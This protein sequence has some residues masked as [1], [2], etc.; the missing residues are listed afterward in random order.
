MSCSDKLAPRSSTCLAMSLAVA[1]ERRKIPHKARSV[2]SGRAKPAKVLQGD[3]VAP[4]A[5]QPRMT[6]AAL[7]AHVLRRMQALGWSAYH[8]YISKRSQPGYPDIAAVRGSRLLYAELKSA[9]GVLTREQRAWLNA[10]WS[11]GAECYVW[12]PK[13]LDWI[14]EV[15]TDDARYGYGG[16]AFRADA[17]RLLLPGVMP[18]N[19]VPY[20]S[21]DV[22]P[23]RSDPA[24]S[25]RPP[26][27][28]RSVRR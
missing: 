2:D 24:V 1:E 15:L 28:T 11:A 14:D 17:A 26:N 6:E 20:F 4:K 7:L 18:L 16:P 22:V 23:A 5:V 12:R 8:T 9:K 10:L 25:G 27:P 19:A 21:P 13:N 3:T